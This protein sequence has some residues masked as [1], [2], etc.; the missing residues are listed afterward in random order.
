MIM[1]ATMRHQEEFIG[2][3]VFDNSKIKKKEKTKNQ[4]DLSEDVRGFYGGK[5][6]RFFLLTA[7]A[8]SEYILYCHHHTSHHLLQLCHYYTITHTLMWHP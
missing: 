7:G 6:N 2:T 1:M 8:F 4:P 5:K 3:L